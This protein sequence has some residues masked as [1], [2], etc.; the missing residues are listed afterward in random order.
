MVDIFGYVL[1]VELRIGLMDKSD[2]YVA[3]WRMLEKH[4]LSTEDRP[5]T[6]FEAWID[7]IWQVQHSTK[8]TKV[9]IGNQLL[10]CNYGESL[11]AL[12]TWAS[13]WG[14]NKSA[15]RKFFILLASDDMIETV[16]ETVTT[17]LKV[18]NYKI[19]DPK[20]QPK[21]NDIETQQNALETHET[22]DKN[23][24]NGNNDK[25]HKEKKKSNNPDGLLPAR[26]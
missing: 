14:W 5:K 25:E 23:V 8:P 10:V 16:N 1:I 26:V 9:K 24:K 17:R 7:I 15:V 11:K 6:Q 22:P 3:I 18:C 2:G 12:G 20:M 4:W 19:Y 21:K 13:R